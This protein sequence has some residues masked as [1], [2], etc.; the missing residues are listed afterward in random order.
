M[1][2]DNQPK[3]DGGTISQIHGKF[4]FDNGTVIW[5]TEMIV[6]GLKGTTFYIQNQILRF[7]TGN[8]MQGTSGTGNSFVFSNAASTP[9]GAPTFAG[10]GNA[11]GTTPGSGLK[12]AG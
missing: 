7:S 11:A 5:F 1:V 10:N 3:I 12:F 6:V 2:M 8:P 4:Q 9:A